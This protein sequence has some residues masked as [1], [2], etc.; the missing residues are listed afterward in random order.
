M[1]SEIMI[2]N[3][4][5]IA[6][7]GD[8]ASKCENTLQSFEKAIVSGAD[9]I[10]LDVRAT[11]DKTLIVHHNRLLRGK[12][13]SSTNWEDIRKINEKK[14]PGIPLL[15][16][17]AQLVQ[18]K[19]KLDIE[20]K[21]V[22]YEKNVLDLLLKYLDPQE[23][24]ITSFNDL[25]VHDI[26]RRDPRIKTGLL[27]SAHKPKRF[28]TAKRGRLFSAKRYEESLADYFL[29]HISLLKFGFLKKLRK[30]EKPIILWTINRKKSIEKYLQDESVSG[31]ITDKLELALQIRNEIEANVS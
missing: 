12:L 3:K 14:M 28:L 2:K 27:L 6:H 29:P 18:G 8:G 15:D 17:V 21:E 25:S 1:N 7:R 5:I 20:L 26:K 24:I 9:M 31:I 19:I 16:E 4:L 11:R 13:I 23:F 10:E 30:Y 22:G